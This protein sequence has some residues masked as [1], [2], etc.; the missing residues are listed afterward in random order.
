MTSKKEIHENIKPIIKKVEK[1]EN[2][3]KIVL[4]RRYFFGFLTPTFEVELSNINIIFIPEIVDDITFC[5]NRRHQYTISYQRIKSLK[6][7]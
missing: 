3:I 1:Y 6:F 5:T 2:G 7:T 4:N